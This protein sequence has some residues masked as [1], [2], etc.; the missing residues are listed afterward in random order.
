MADRNWPG[1]ED[2]TCVGR[3]WGW[4]AERGPT[5]TPT[6]TEQLQVSPR[7]HADAF[8]RSVRAPKEG[9]EELGIEDRM[10]AMS[11]TPT[12]IPTQPPPPP[13]TSPKSTFTLPAS[14]GTRSDIFAVDGESRTAVSEIERGMGSMSITPSPNPP[15]PPPPTPSNPLTLPPLRGETGPTLLVDNESL[16][17]ELAHPLAP[18]LTRPSPQGTPTRSTLEKASGGAPAYVGVGS[19]GVASEGGEV[20]EGEETRGKRA[21]RGRQGGSSKRRGRAA[22]RRAEGS[23]ND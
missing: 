22:E 12:P 1:G 9:G 6:S 4:D 2:G 7:Q 15:K 3:E 8:L 20:A 23:S 17:P 16:T 14:L 19:S 5:I 11:M 21:R 18:A 10:G 13:Q